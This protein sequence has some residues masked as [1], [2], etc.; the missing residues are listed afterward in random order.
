MNISRTHLVL[1]AVA[2][3]SGLTACSATPAPS[4]AVVEGRA[5]L[6]WHLGEG[7]PPEEP[8]FA[9][10]RDVAV[11]AN[12]I[13]VADWQRVTVVVLDADGDFLN[14][15]G[16]EGQGPGEFRRP[17]FLAPTQSGDLYVAAVPVWMVDRFTSN[18]EFIERSDHLELIGEGVGRLPEG[19]RIRQPLIVTGDSRF[20]W[21]MSV[22]RQALAEQQLATPPLL[23]INGDQWEFLGTRT[24]PD[25]S[26]EVRRALIES[27]D[28]SFISNFTRGEPVEGL[29][30]GEV[31]FVRRSD[32]YT[33]FRFTGGQEDRSF[34]YTEAERA[35]W[36]QRLNYPPGE[37]EAL[38]QSGNGRQIGDHIILQPERPPAV[39][40]TFTFTHTLRGVARLGTKLFTYVEVLKE[41]FAD[42]PTDDMVEKKLYVIDLD[43]ER[44]EMVVPIDIPGL[45]SL[46][47]AL[48]NG[49]L[50]FAALLADPGIYVYRIVT[51]D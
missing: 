10:A 7:G 9:R 28:Q 31:L 37:S 8:W 19:L 49:N 26:D 45:V 24:L 11:A 39:N 46:E 36:V 22:S 6:V 2:L 32:P 4:E 43:T 42:Q 18:G 3:V 50:V 13:Y 14:T 40:H 30:P 5:E 33:V 38:R 35:P 20:V 51:E 16:Q 1:L 44:L 34:V 23:Q 41:G 29:I 21:S 48:D 27:P 12:K 17:Q 15:I 25:G 47:G